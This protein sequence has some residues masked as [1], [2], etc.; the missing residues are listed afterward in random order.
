MGQKKGIGDRYQA[1]TKYDRGRMPSYYLDWSSQPEPFKIYRGK[2]KRV[3]LKA[4]QAQ[5]GMSLFEALAQRRSIRDF[6]EAPL[7]LAELSQ[8]VWCTQGTTLRMG[9]I[10][11]RTA[12][13]AGGL[14]PI[15]TYLVANRVE[16][17]AAGVYHVDVQHEELEQIAEGDYSA[18]IAMAS[19]NQYMAQKAAVVFVWTAVTPR[20][21]WKYRERAFRYIY[22][23]AGHIG[24]NL[25]LAA[26]AMG[27][28]CCTIG[29]FYDEE[30]N[31][32]LGID[33]SEEMAIYLGAVGRLA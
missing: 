5:G 20:S 11:F 7:A 25:Y 29:A 16:E 2:L 12:P 14:Y 6:C 28:G 21:K 1:E 3:P 15:E 10:R 23:D 18:A 26:T 17:L 27:L 33:G 30:V 24:Q 4:G 22:M 9:D 31:E 19:L 32:I 13:S 8:L